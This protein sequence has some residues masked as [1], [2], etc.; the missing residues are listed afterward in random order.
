MRKSILLSIL[1]CAVTCGLFSCSDHEDFWGKH[2]YT[3]EELEAIRV[4][5][6]IKEA[7]KTQIKADFIYKYEL[8]IPKNDE[9][10]G[11]EFKMDSVKMA[12]D[13]GYDSP[14][15]LR[16]ALGSGE[17]TQKDFEVAFFN[18]VGPDYFKVAYTANNLGYWID[19]DGG[20]CGW[21]KTARLFFELYPED[22]F[23]MNIGQYPE[24]C[25]VGDKFVAAFGFQNKEGK[26]LA[27]V[28]NITIGAAK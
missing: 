21:G 11:S 25:A 16:I 20:V 3:P 7:Q 14:K 4:Q 12:K 13:L 24:V 27:T 26:V 2:E 28:F 22:E 6:S 5:D 15:D 9:Y 23:L 8:T 1:I 17:G 18:I 10:A 19:K